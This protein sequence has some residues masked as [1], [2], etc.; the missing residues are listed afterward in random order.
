MD[1]MEIHD[2]Y[3][4][5]VRAFI[6]G[7]VR[8]RSV[9]DDLVQETFLRVQENHERLRDLAKLPAWIFRIAHNLCQDHFRKRKESPLDGDGDT[10]TACD[11]QACGM[12]K[13]MEQRQMSQCV[14]EKVNLLPEPLRAVL[15][16]FDTLALSHQEI[17]D[18]LGITTA[19]TKV[20]LHRARRKLKQILEVECTFE[21]DERDVLVCE[22]ARPGR[23]G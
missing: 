23:S 2:Q 10:G 15:I 21:R 8:D 5:R 7:M 17:A 11:A 22:P 14:Q 9:A 3:S 16:L 6:L 18:A 1:F 20:R 19:N 4:P 13:E 12:Q